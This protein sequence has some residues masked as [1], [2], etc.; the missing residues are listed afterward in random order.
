MLLAG[1]A[2]EVF[3]TD[4]AGAHRC[5]RGRLDGASVVSGLPA[6]CLALCLAAGL[7]QGRFIL[8]G[9]RRRLAGVLTV[10]GGRL[11][12]EDRAYQ[13]Q[14]CEHAAHQ[15]FGFTGNTLLRGQPLELAFQPSSLHELMWC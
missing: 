1:C 11:F 10:F 7:T 3:T 13:L 2:G 5:N 8:V 6:F 14:Q 4:I 9:L 15:H 12:E